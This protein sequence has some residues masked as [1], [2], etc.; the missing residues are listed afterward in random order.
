MGLFSRNT[1]QTVVDDLEAVKSF[2]ES[3]LSEFDYI[4]SGL[5]EAQSGLVDVKASA[6]ADIDAANAAI[7][8]AQARIAEADKHSSRYATVVANIEKLLGV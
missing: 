1:V 3:V 8:T 6:Q 7:A 4:T 2:G 5:K